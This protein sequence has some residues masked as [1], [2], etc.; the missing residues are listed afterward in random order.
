[1]A[2]FSL[3]GTLIDVMKS[4]KSSNT[5]KCWHTLS[6]I[7]V[8]LI[9]FLDF[10]NHTADQTYGISPQG[11]LWRRINLQG[12]S[13]PHARHNSRVLE[14]CSRPHSYLFFM[15]ESSSRMTLEGQGIISGL[16]IT[17]P[18]IGIQRTYVHIIHIVT[19]QLI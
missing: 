11:S 18:T 19:N 9:V 8:M 6:R 14:S 13:S 2:I 10:G 12:C 15:T 16:S 4:S 17:I 1:M 3:F 7:H 5:S